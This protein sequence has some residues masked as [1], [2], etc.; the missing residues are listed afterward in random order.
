[1]ALH[2]ILCSHY[3]LNTA[4]CLLGDTQRPED[5]EEQEMSSPLT[6]NTGLLKAEQQ[7]LPA[8]HAGRTQTTCYKIP[9]CLD[10]PREMAL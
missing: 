3:T 8:P 6:P 9:V 2:S 10:Y 1:M 7:S 4:N 5:N